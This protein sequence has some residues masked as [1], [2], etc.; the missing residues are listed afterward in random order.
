MQK[1]TAMPANLGDTALLRLAAAPRLGH[2]ARA[3]ALCAEAGMG[4]AA[5]DWPLGTRDA[6]L[7]RLRAQVFGPEVPCVDTC[8]TCQAEVALSA[9]LPDLLALGGAPAGPLHLSDGPCKAR[10]LTTRDL[11]AAA[12]LSRKAA[13]AHLAQAAAGRAVSLDADLAIIEDWL[14]AADPLAHVSFDLECV[15]CSA[16][17]Q[18]PFDIVAILWAEARAAGRR[19]VADIHALASA[20]HW[21]EAE[22]L[23][24]PAERRALYLAMVAP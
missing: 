22:I 9:P 18:R 7:M 20:Y 8:A 5:A 16:R 21:S 2:P 19:L 4:A 14:D 10:P 15:A 3:L 17:W 1:V 11:L 12:T 23:A 13:R 24:V 6:A